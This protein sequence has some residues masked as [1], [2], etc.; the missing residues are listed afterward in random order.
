M[1][2]ASDAVQ[3]AIVAAVAAVT[4]AVVSTAG[5]I[6]VARITH[7]ARISSERAAVSSDRAADHA[8][9]ATEVAELVEQHVRPVNGENLGELA[10]G[11]KGR[12]ERV[13]DLIEQLERSIAADHRATLSL[14][15]DMQR[16]TER[17]RDLAKELADH[18]EAAGPLASYVEFLMEREHPGG[19]DNG[20]EGG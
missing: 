12:I 13:H 10:E 6:I 11:N 18:I 9:K 17:I 2:A 20:T 15:A 4:T 8:A 7:A 16:Q 3:A 19:T 1:L 5:V 14:S